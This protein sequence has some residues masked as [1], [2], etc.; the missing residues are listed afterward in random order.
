M[1]VYNTL[2]DLASLPEAESKVVRRRCA[3]HQ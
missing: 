2:A 3:Q 1:Q